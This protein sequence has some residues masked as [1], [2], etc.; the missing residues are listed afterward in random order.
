M[1]LCEY[2]KALQTK[3]VAVIGIGISNIP[4]IRMLC[5][6]GVSVTACDRK[7]RDALG[8]LADELTSLGCSLKLGDNYLDGLN[9]DVVFRTP[10]LHPRYLA[11]IQREGCTITSEMEV[12]F[13][14]CPCPIIAVTGSD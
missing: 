3:K 6:A 10:G 5:E 7:N 14:V 12:F 1:T 8:K 4:L 9:A 13:D 11:E 2:L